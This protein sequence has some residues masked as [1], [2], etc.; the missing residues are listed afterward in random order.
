[1]RLTRDLETNLVRLEESGADGSWRDRF[2]GMVPATGASAE[3]AAY[4]DQLEQLFQVGGESPLRALFDALHPEAVFSPEGLLAE[5]LLH[6]AGRASEAEVPT[7]TPERRQQEIAALAAEVAADREE[8]RKGEEYLAWI[9]KRHG[10]DGKGKAPAAPQSAAGKAAARNRGALERQRDALQADLRKQ[11]LPVRLPADLPELFDKAEGLRQELAALQLELTPLQRRRQAMVIPGLLWPLLATLA[12]LAAPGV[13][14]WLKAP[15]LLP[16]AAG[17]GTLLLL[18][19]GVYLVRLSRARAARDGLDQELQGVETKRADAL[20]RQSDLAEQFEAYG[21]SSTPVEM[22]K[23]QQL[24][25]RNEELLDRYREVCQELGDE[26]V[27]SP[28]AGQRAADDK[29]LRPED[30]PEAEARLAAMAESLRRREARLQAL[31]DGT[32]TLE[33]DAA[34]PPAARPVVKEHALMHAIGQHLER[35][36]A[37]R[38]QNVR[39]EE[40]RLRVEAAPGRWAAPSACSRGT[41]ACLA[42]AVRLAL[43]Q[44]CAGRL[45][46]PVDDLTTQLDAK[47]RQVAQR[48]LERFALDH[49]LL[50]ATSD[51]ELAKRAAKERWHVLGLAGRQAGQ[52]L[53][54]EEKADAGQMHLL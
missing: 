49:Q 34:P 54:A 30:L 17:C 45:P 48:A 22:V 9:R 29:H 47:R 12:G 19:W 26:P 8:Y 41:A 1:V 31:R 18:V 38:Y 14:F 20:S 35:L 44:E 3:R 32:A 40:G 13:A 51:E 53:A 2:A 36:T 27:S 23:L 50:L 5:G 11:G 6:N 43:C 15:W 25:R 4:F 24:C 39:L 42:L 28:A 7:V 10:L 37:G 33:S 16:L 46:L 52:P 21:L